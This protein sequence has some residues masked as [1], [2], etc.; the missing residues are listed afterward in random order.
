[1]ER[2][3]GFV[4]L[5]SGVSDN[6]KLVK[7][8]TESERPIY[9]K[10]RYVPPYEKFS[11]LKNLL[12]RVKSMTDVNADSTIAVDMAEWIG[13]EDDEYFTVMLKY[14][15]DQRSHWRYVITVSNH[16][17]EEASMLYLRL[18]LYLAGSLIEDTTF[19]DSVHLSDY[20]TANCSI[21]AAASQ[22]L[23]A[24]LL[25]SENKPVK[26]FELVDSVIL[27]LNHWSGGGTVSVDDIKRYFGDKSTI[28]SMLAEQNVYGKG[29]DRYGF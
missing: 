22:L 11:E 7:K 27:E 10:S 23:A 14:L 25:D 28:L 16:T 4:L 29:N 24:Q 3:N 1:M 8:L 9:Y 15:H 13:H 5:I 21:D 20:I 19:L 6:D 26:S 12:L 17:K 18:R 2:N